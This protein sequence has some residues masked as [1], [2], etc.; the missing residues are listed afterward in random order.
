MPSEG[1]EPAIT[2]IK[3]LQT[4][5][6]DCAATGIGNINIYKIITLVFSYN[7]CETDSSCMG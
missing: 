6:L 1:F 7:R 3:Q 4:Y 5:A 2:A